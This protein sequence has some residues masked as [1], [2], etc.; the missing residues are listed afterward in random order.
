MIS[1]L[2]CALVGVCALF[3]PQGSKSNPGPVAGDEIQ[4]AIGRLAIMDQTGFEFAIRR[5]VSL[6][7]PAVPRMAN[8]IRDKGFSAQIRNGCLQALQRIGDPAKPA[9]DAAIQVLGDKLPILRAQSLVLIGQIGLP[10]ARKAFGAVRALRADKD[11]TVRRLSLYVSTLL[12]QDRAKFLPEVVDGLK[13]KDTTVHDYA[14]RTMFEFYK[15]YAAP[16]LE[17]IL[18]HVKS[19]DVH[20]MRNTKRLIASM[21]D[22]AVPR[23]IDALLDSSEGNRAYRLAAMEIVGIMRPVRKPAIEA[24]MRAYRELDADSAKRTAD[25]M[26]RLGAHVASQVASVASDAKAPESLRLR[27]MRDLAT[28]GDAS[29]DQTSAFLA[30]LASESEEFRVTTLASIS[31]IRAGVRDV[32]KDVV[33]FLSAK[34][35]RERLGAAAALG[36][37]GQDATIAL[38]KIL[39]LM[40]SSDAA[41][42][43]VGIRA[44]T[45]LNVRAAP[46][47][48]DLVALLT[49]DAPA[50]RLRAVE[51]L[52]RIGAA[53]VPALL[54]VAEAGDSPRLQRG[55]VLTFQAI[56][57]AAGVDVAKVVTALER[58][59]AR[60][61]SVLQRDAAFALGR[62]GTA[63]KSALPRLQKLSVDGET[64]V[65]IAAL[66]ALRVIDGA[67]ESVV[68]VI[69]KSLSDKVDSVRWAA[70]EALGVMGSKV[71]VP[72]LIPFVTS[73]D[74][75]DRIKA[76]DAL[77]SIGKLA[78]DALPVIEKQLRRETVREATLALARGANRIKGAR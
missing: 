20:V 27:A 22:A 34:S 66:G 23:L 4:L 26:R 45:A 18:P 74:K 57:P 65:R 42:N 63:A 2:P 68:R 10:D 17:R 60:D 40:Q 46:L 75:V 19:R 8:V 37:L 62:I 51:G 7:S 5:L 69:E 39:E 73:E 50:R 72:L 1:I 15:E 30:G 58:S 52:A 6:G 70:I 41:S 16:Y 77:G 38:P 35:R 28:I 59:L 33:P 61:E 56:G 36:P 9:L 29:R 49:V 47:A 24:L 31:K 12:A 43:R 78:E 48:K 54:E 3:A 11:T 32:A 71:A 67:S 25:T 55:I 44:L 53:A 64:E 76:G 13:D 21:G 14:I